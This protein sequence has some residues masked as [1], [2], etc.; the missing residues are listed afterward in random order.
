MQISVIAPEERGGS[1][2]KFNPSYQY[3]CAFICYLVAEPI[4]SSDLF[5]LTTLNIPIMHTSSLTLVIS[6]TSPL[7]TAIRFHWLEELSI[8][9]LFDWPSSRRKCIWPMEAGKRLGVQTSA[10]CRG[11]VHRL[12]TQC[13]WRLCYNLPPMDPEAGNMV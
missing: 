10:L 2:C 12:P 4:T 5:L 6:T 13:Y 1:A 7:L 11:D 3:H 9:R 8:D